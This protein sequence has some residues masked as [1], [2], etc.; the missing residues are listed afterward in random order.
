MKAVDRK[1]YCPDEQIS[2]SA[3]DHDE[4]TRQQHHS[5][6]GEHADIAA[7]ALLLA[8]SASLAEH[9]ASDLKVIDSN[10]LHATACPGNEIIQ[11][12]SMR[13][14]ASSCTKRIHLPGRLMH[15]CGHLHSAYEDFPQRIG[16]QATISAPSMHA[17]CLSHL[18]EHLKPGNAVQPCLPPSGLL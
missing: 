11:P 18:E 5:S 16:W 6:F 1:D 4:G 2:F 14:A 7:E 9:A 3:D 13:S 10:T 12:C 8:M 15:N 17:I